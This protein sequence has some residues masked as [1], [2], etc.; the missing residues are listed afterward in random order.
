MVDAARADLRDAA[1]RLVAQQVLEA[2]AAIH[3]TG[4]V[5]RDV[6][7][8][9]ILVSE[10]EC[11]LKFIDFGAAADLRVGINYE[12]NEFLLDPRFAPPQ[13]YVMSTQTPQ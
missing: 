7:P 1:L 9:N 3:R 11:R 10:K 5:H 12:P 13:Q 2:L 4:I 6:K 8:Q